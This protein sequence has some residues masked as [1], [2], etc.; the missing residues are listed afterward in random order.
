MLGVAP[1]HLALVTHSIPGSPQES[2]HVCRWPVRRYQ[3]T[4]QGAAVGVV[5]IV[6]DALFILVLIL[7]GPE[8]PLVG[9]AFFLEP[10]LVLP[11]FL[12][13]L[14]PYLLFPLGLFLGLFLL[15]PFFLVVLFFPVSTPVRKT[16][17]V[18]ILIPVVSVAGKIL[19]LIL[20]E[21]GGP[22]E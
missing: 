4:D 8:I 7:I 10:L 17:A 9:I 19:V 15:A 16:T 12:M 13:A 20:G 3:L 18:V 22:L 1:L 21:S 2:D 11:A 14:L 5:V 6:S